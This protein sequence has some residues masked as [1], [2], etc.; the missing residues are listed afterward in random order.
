MNDT[1]TPGVLIAGVALIIVL[2]GGAYGV[3][4]FLAAAAWVSIKFIDEKE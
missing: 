1:I 3:G 2:G 4:A